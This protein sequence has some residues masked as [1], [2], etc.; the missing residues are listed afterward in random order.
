MAINPNFPLNPPNRVWEP[1]GNYTPD[2]KPMFASREWHKGEQA[3]YIATVL[4]PMERQ[5]QR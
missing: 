2:G 4:V 3:E 5:R 1:T